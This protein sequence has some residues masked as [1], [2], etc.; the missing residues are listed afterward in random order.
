MTLGEKILFYRKQ[1]KLSQEELNAA[2]ARVKEIMA[3]VGNDQC[4]ISI[5][6]GISSA[7]DVAKV[8]AS[9]AESFMIG[10]AYVKALQDGQPL[11]QV[12]EYLKGVR[13][14]CDLSL[15]G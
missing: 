12:S 8:R 13:A 1:N 4:T 6:C 9:G 3:R 10:S 5:V 14:M 2:V 15:E 7:E 11:D